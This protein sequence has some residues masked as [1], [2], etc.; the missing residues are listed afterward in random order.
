MTAHDTHLSEHAVVKMSAARQGKT[1]KASARAALVEHVGAIHAF[2]GPF[3]THG[4]P[5]TLIVD[6]RARVAQFERALR[7]RQVEQSRRERP[8]PGGA[9]ASGRHRRFGAIDSPVT[10]S[11]RRNAE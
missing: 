3:I 6:L 7:D 8:H 9:H 10:T 11:N 1:T 2:A 4:L 5:P